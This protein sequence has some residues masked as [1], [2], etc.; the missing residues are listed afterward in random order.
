[1]A[2]AIS[3]L[4]YP[5]GKSC[6][7]DVTTELIRINKLDRCHYAEP[8]AGGCGLALAL[9]VNGHVSDIHI[10]DLDPSIWAIWNSILNDT[11]AFLKLMKRT[12]I[13]IKEWHRQ[14]EIYRRHD[15]RNPLK[16][17]F[18]A[19]F[20]NRTNRSGIIGTGGVIGGLKQDGNYLIDC[21]FN[22]EGLEKRIKRIAKYRDLI[23]LTR[24][25]AL[26]FLEHCSTNLPANSF[27][28]IDP[29]YYAKGAS[30]YAN[31]YKPIDHIAVAE[32]VLRGDTENK[33]AKNYI[34]TYDD[35]DA[36]RRLYRSRRQFGFD[37]Q[38]SLQAKRLGTE[39]MIV[40]KGLKV[41]ASIRKRRV[42][43]LNSSKKSNKKLAVV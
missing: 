4:R 22:K 6:L 38:Y 15:C 21:R 14:R 25:D 39:L 9:L 31:S 2:R 11:D 33:S 10:N 3:P 5:G 26:D 29:P 34:V 13:T 12:P 19:F 23:H 8:Y 35:V 36:I 43:G 42:T 7:F 32:R 17:G 16:L 24:M 30:L 28:C 20:L 40:S 27:L 18:S 37:V 1:M 41:P